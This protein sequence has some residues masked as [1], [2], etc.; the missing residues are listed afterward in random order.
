[1]VLGSPAQVTPD[2]FDTLESF[3]H[4]LKGFGNTLKDKA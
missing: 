1:M 2:I 4:K 3:S